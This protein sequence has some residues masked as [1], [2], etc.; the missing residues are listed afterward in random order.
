MKLSEFVVGASREMDGTA[1]AINE[2]RFA[3]NISNVVSSA[4]FGSIV[5]GNI[6]EFMKFMSS[7]TVVSSGGNARFIS[8]NGVPADNVPVTIVWRHT[9]P[10]YKSKAQGL[11]RTQYR[12]VRISS[13]P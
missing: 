7:I 9:G 1:I 4:E 13:S 6:G 10:I 11:K 2:Q 5:E 12:Q 8:I 3:A